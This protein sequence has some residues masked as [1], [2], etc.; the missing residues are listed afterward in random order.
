MDLA[1]NHAVGRGRGRRRGNGAQLC[2][3]G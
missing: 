3:P 2:N 1:I